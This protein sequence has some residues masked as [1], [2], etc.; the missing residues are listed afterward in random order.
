MVSNIEK[1][2]A[3]LI[4]K[5]AEEG[6]DPSR[7]TLNFV[8]TK[9]GG[10]IYI[11]EDGNCFRAYDYIRGAVTYQAAGDPM[12][13]YNSGRAFGK[14]QR[15]LGDFDVSLLYE[16]LPR[17]HDTRKRYD[18]LMAAVAQDKMSR[19]E[20]CA[21][22]IGF[23]RQR[24]DMCSVL[25]DLKNAGKIPQRVTHNDTKLN[26]VMFDEKTG[27]GICVI[28]LDTVMPGLS[29]YDFGDSIR[30]GANAAAEDETDLSKVSLDLTLF[31]A[32]TKGYLEEAGV[33]L[34]DTE[35]EYLPFSAILITLECGI[36]FLTDYLE[37]D[38]Y[39]KISRE[40]HNLDRCRTQ[41]R[42][43]EDMESKLGE[44]KRIVA[45]YS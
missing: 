25:T 41:F 15:R 22:E 2:T 26:N 16:T 33:S 39:F 13:F 21:G 29:L 6:G 17:F 20:E 44:M 5:I 8:Q 7:E 31:E 36:R 1:I 32:Y 45:K 38:V 9:Q 24:R 11:D 27:E 23:V 43:V 37:G 19:A 12:L 35:K 28:D 14:F 34:N 30:F 10:S 3:H 18:D 42:L 4:R 40:K